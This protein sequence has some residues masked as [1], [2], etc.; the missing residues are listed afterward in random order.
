MPRFLTDTDDGTSPGYRGE[1]ST[2]LGS[3]GHR[4]GEVVAPRWEEVLAD[5]SAAVKAEAE[6]RA[7]RVI[8]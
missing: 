5:T 4:W 8:P 1:L 6:R 2:D 3:L 7:A